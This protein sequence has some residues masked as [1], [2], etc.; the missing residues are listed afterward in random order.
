MAKERLKSPRARL[1]VALDLPG[2]VRVEIVE[3]GYEALADPALRPVAPESLHVTL[4]FLGYLPEREIEPLARIVRAAAGP[5][6]SIELGDPVPRPQGGRPRLFAL[7]AASV[8]TI[9]LQARL[10]QKL[11]A[12]RL[13][14]PEKRPFWPHVTVARV[15]R[16]ERG[17]KRPALVSRPPGTLPKSLL[18]SFDGVRIVLYLSQIKPQGAQYTPL[19]QVELPAGGWQ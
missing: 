7:P 3:W 11:V 17:S 8:G 9:A 4:A 1:F 12:A 16:E 13:Y 5:A 19:A 10:A 6:P 2:S 14:K 15:R 18:Q